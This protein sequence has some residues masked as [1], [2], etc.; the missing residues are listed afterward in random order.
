[1]GNK[2]VKSNLEMMI[3]DIKFD[4]RSSTEDTKFPHSD[5]NQNNGNNNS[6]WFKSMEAC[7][8]SSAHQTLVYYTWWWKHFL[9]TWRGTPKKAVD[10]C[11]RPRVVSRSKSL[12]LSRHSRKW[13]FIPQLLQI[14]RVEFNTI[15]SLS[16]A[17]VP[18]NNSAS[19]VEINPTTAQTRQ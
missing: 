9:K 3:S 6:T 11:L 7:S 10:S 1:M 19:A 16:Y 12:Y 13:E 14:V 5:L 15:F 2:E 17:L 8:P 18:D 4:N